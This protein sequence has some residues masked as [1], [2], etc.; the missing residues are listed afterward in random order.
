MSRIVVELEK[1]KVLISGDVKLSKVLDVCKA[2]FSD[3]SEV[4]IEQEGVFDLGLP[5]YPYPNSPSL[6]NTPWEIPSPY[7]PNRVWYTNDNNGGLCV[8]D[9]SCKV[10]SGQMKLDFEES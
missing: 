10:D 8:C 1:K 6:P 2:L 5:S 9:N 4:S 7:D 3:L